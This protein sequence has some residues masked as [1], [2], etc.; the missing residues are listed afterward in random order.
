MFQHII[1]KYKAL[2]APVRASGWFFVCAFCQKGISFITTPIFTRL[3]SAAEYGAYSVFQ[4][5]MGMITIFVS[6]N[7]NCGVYTRGLVQFEEE[8]KEFSSSMQGLCLTSAAAWLGIY[9]LFRDVWN[10]LFSLTT[11]QMLAMFLIIWTS[12][13]FG[14]WSVE[15]RVEL[16]YQ[17]LVAVTL[18]VSLIQPAVGIAFVSRAQDKATARIL[19]LALVNAAAYSGLFVSQMRRGKRFFVRKFWK[20]AARFNLPLLPH[21]LSQSILSGADRIMIERMAGADKAGIYNLACSVS[22][23]MTMFHTAL[24]QTV[25]PWL[26]QKIK[27]GRTDVLSAVAYPAFGAVAGVNLL[28]IAFAPEIITLFAPDEYREAIWA[29]P[30]VVMSVYFTFAYTFFAVFEFY[31]EKTQYIA[32]ATAAGAV[33]NIALNRI[34]IPRFGYYA[35]GYTTLACY[36]IYAVFHYCF[37]RK[38]CRTRLGGRQAYRTRILLGITACFMLL[39]FGLMFT[40]TNAVLRYVWIVF[41]AGVLAVRRKRLQLYLK[42]L[43]KLPKA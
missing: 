32:T 21:Y 30:P 24:M 27:E 33:L 10:R 3:L 18:L 40:Y 36:M 6:L 4:S 31:F 19:G 13:S 1:G 23:I 29:I 8:R 15:Q 22:M 14:F 41:G 38:L 34:C 9:L 43:H 42:S 39:G 20:H 2:P 28:L 25:E 37:M 16:R 35:A 11:L 26:Y 5:W 12:A 7:L 17:R